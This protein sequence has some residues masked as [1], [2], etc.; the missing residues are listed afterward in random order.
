MVLSKRLTAMVTGVVIVIVVILI[1]FIVTSQTSNSASPISRRTVARPLYSDDADSPLDE[2][3][4]EWKSRLT[5]DQYMVTRKKGT[6]APFSGKYWNHKGSG[7]YKCVCCATPL[8]D[9]STKFDSG[10]GWPSF[11]QPIDDKRIETSVDFSLFT[12]RTEVLCRNCKAHLGHVYDDG[13]QPT[14]LRY[15]INSV[16]LDFQEGDS[17]PKKSQ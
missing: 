7:L 9:S 15:S 2:K 12:Q 16:A 4:K 3:D 6:E 17:R 10:T 13:P 14:G 5:Y 11:Y 1:G 8:F